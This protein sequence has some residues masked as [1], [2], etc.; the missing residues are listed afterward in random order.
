MSELVNKSDFSK[1]KETRTMIQVLIPLYEDVTQ[2]DFTGPI[3]FFENVPGIELIV[4]S[5]GGRSIKSKSLTFTDLADLAKIERCDVLC[6]P[7]GPG[8]ISA[9]ENETFLSEIQRLGKT[10]K[11]LTSVCV[12]SLIL[13]AAGFLEGRKAACHWAF[14]DMLSEFGAIAD[15]A[16]VVRD[17][18]IITGGGVTAGI[19]FA[20]TLIA[21]LF[22][23]ETAQ[24]VSLLVEYAPAPPFGPGLPEES[25]AHVS[26][27]VNEQLAEFIADCRSRVR[28]VSHQTSID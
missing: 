15:S 3:E 26:T 24:R 17:G 5:V 20:Q 6:I 4:G 18:N 7:G 11:Y 2:L 25:P 19:D 21:E 8:F 1:P 27:A 10:A 14:R 22:D 12:G 16:R 13:A 28:A 9:I 23:I